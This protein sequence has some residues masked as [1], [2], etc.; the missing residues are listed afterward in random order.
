MSIENLYQCNLRPFQDDDECLW[1][2][3]VLAPSHEQ[4]LF[5]ALL[6][7][8]SDPQFWADRTRHLPGFM[9]PR[10]KALTR[11][12]SPQDCWVESEW[13]D[14]VADIHPTA[15]KTLLDELQEEQL[16]EL[17]SHVQ[18]YYPIAF[19]IFKPEIL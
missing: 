13:E 7:V 6:N 10:M 16:T 8:A 14:W 12:S 15:L 9:A 18:S 5:K 3:L 4:V 19:E 1:T 17:L 2:F 11:E